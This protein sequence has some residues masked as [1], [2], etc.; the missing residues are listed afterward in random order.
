MDYVEIPGAL[1]NKSRK[2][3]MKK[4]FIFKNN[5]CLSEAILPKKWR[6]TTQETGDKDN[7]GKYYLFYNHKNK[8]FCIGCYYWSLYDGTGAWYDFEPDLKKK[9][10]NFQ[11]SSGKFN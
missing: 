5:H 3:L 11:S 6:Y 9:E 7:G 4:G 1:A 8:L 2:I 10:Y